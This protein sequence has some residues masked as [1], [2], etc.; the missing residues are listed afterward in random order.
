[1]WNQVLEIVNF[2]SIIDILIAAFVIYKAMMIIKGT[3]AVQLIKG[4][5]VLLLASWSASLLVLHRKLDIGSVE[6][7]AC[8]GFT[9][10]FS[11]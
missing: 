3:R 9:S 6:D 2:I 5:I 11:A 10:C 7:S 1:M 8:R 4:L